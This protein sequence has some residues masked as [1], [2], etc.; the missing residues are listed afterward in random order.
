VI[1]AIL[2]AAAVGLWALLFG[3]ETLGSRLRIRAGS[4]INPEADN[5]HFD[6]VLTSLFG[7][8]ALLMGFTFSM[9]LDRYDQRSSDVVT[10]AIAIGSAHQSAALLGSQQGKALQDVLQSYAELRL[11]YGQATLADVQPLQA[12]SLR[13]RRQIA[14]ASLAATLPIANTLLGSMII[15]SSDTVGDAGVQRDAAMKARLPVS[16]FTV[17][18]LFTCVAMGM[19][20]FAYP[21]LVGARRAIS[22][23][24]CGLLVVTLFLIIDLDRPRGGTIRI[25]QDAMDDLV[26]DLRSNQ[27]SQASAQSL[28]A[29]SDRVP[30]K[31]LASSGL[32]V[33]AH[34]A[35]PGI[36][37]A[38]A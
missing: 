18:I 30:D 5:K 16:V 4:T 31:Q 8:L 12:E 35:D 22:Q 36:G 19:T 33:P 9:A 17:L 21:S 14:E 24:V 7:L 25:S 29:W 38:W 28:P 34:A 37:Q 10:E 27:T 32:R 26:K 11:R 2:L 20:G 3:L 13:V 23:L 6:H 15:K 1:D